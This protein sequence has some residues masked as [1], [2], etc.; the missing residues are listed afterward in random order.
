MRDLRDGW[1]L[2]SVRGLHSNDEC[3][4]KLSA[5]SPLLKLQHNRKIVKLV[6]EIECSA[7]AAIS[8]KDKKNQLHTNLLSHRDIQT[9][10]MTML[11]DCTVN[12]YGKQC[13]KLRAML[14]NGESGLWT[15][16]RQVETL[17]RSIV[18]SEDDVSAAC[19]AAARAETHLAKA[20]ALEAW[21]KSSKCCPSC[22]T[23][24]VL[25][26]D[27]ELY[28]KSVARLGSVE[29]L[30]CNTESVAELA[31]TLRQ[32]NEAKN[33]AQSFLSNR[34]KNLMEASNTLA[35]L[36]S[37]RTTLKENLEDA[38]SKYSK[39]VEKEEEIKKGY[40]E[41]TTQVE[42]CK[43]EIYALDNK[44]DSENE[45]ISTLLAEYNQLAAGN[46][47][48]TL[49][50]SMPD[51]ILGRVPHLLEYLDAEISS[52][53]AV[54]VGVGGGGGGGEEG[55]AAAQLP[56]D[57]AYKEKLDQDVR[58]YKAALTLGKFNV[59]LPELRSALACTNWMQCKCSHVDQ[60][61][62]VDELCSIFRRSSEHPQELLRRV[63]DRY[64]YLLAL[65]TASKRKA[66][67]VQ[68]MVDSLDCMIGNL[69]DKLLE[70]GN[71]KEKVVE[72][73]NALAEVRAKLIHS[74][75]VERAQNLKHTTDQLRAKGDGLQEE[76]TT[77]GTLCEMLKKA[78]HDTLEHLVDQINQTW[79]KLLENMLTDSMTVR[80]SLTKEY[81][82]STPSYEVNVVVSKGA[83]DVGPLSVLSGGE[84]EKIKMMFF[85]C[86][87]KVTHGRLMIVD[88]RL[89]TLDS[90]SMDC[91]LESISA[92]VEGLLV[93]VNH[94]CGA[95]IYDECVDVTNL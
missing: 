27:M 59:D 38:I 63:V 20:S 56:D 4:G 11:R 3:E 78:N 14:R 34:T 44:L 18:T 33:I 36:N 55:A 35:N 17:K 54:G 70:L 21:G 5:V 48:L 77:Q 57:P 95:G 50:H 82:N 75:E 53:L 88:E 37:A 62:A 10:T 42:K 64:V 74:E 2:K 9:A 85:M 67:T 94:R 51:R 41:V 68:E 49:E 73:G 16:E 25:G 60:T 76:L 79:N 93:M 28:T 58:Y 13:I 52:A 32:A 91:V 12:F 71:S 45:K 47:A 84:Q 19:D 24:L 30:P 29:L 7:E 46:A 8:C 86:M 23:E 40:D 89:S 26:A 69:E 22:E 90:D 83:V 61:A 15:Q 92:N 72:I 81:R 87:Q 31:D 43:R 39:E 6:Q 66:E 65:E 1:V 80:L